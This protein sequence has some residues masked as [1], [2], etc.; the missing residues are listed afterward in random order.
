MDPSNPLTDI[1]QVLAISKLS[2]NEFQS[3]LPPSQ[4][5]AFLNRAFGGITSGLCLTAAYATVPTTHHV[6]SV[7]GNFLGPALIDRPLIM[8]VRRIRDTRTFATRQV[9][10][11]QIMDDG[12][13][14]TCLLI[15]SDFMAQEKAAALRY[16]E[17]PRRNWGRPE[18]G[19]TLQQLASQYVQEG[20]IAKTLKDISEK[21]I[22]FAIG[23]FDMRFASGAPFGDSLMGGAK[24]LPH[25]QDG[26]PIAE[27]VSAD[28]IRPWAKVSTEAEHA[29][30]L[31]CLCDLA[32]S[33]IAI[34][35][36]KQNLGDYGAASSLEFSL[37][38]FSN[39]IDMNEF[40]LREMSARTGAEGRSF[41][42]QR[43]WDKDMNMVACM[44]Q[45]VIVRPKEASATHK[46][47]I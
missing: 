37:R 21:S 4:I 7:Q 34:A 31:A 3:I 44:T 33:F 40:H 5:G 22:S 32:M 24:H 25:E 36:N 13:S 2:E 17:K 28:W 19:R 12:S 41:H 18:D 29:G 38:F 26:L 35:H 39:K 42:E 1:R 14:R 47:K 8:N 46:S 23:C 20:K 45:Q 15:I 30:A 10:A 9:E 11:R 6:Y 27:K 16:T 43:I